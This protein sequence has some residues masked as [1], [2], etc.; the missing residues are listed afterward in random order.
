M[1]TLRPGVSP[2]F[3]PCIFISGPPPPLFLLPETPHA[4][5]PPL[6]LLPELELDAVRGG[7]VV[8]CCRDSAFCS[9]LLRCRFSRRSSSSCNNQTP[10][11]SLD[12]GDAGLGAVEA[13]LW[14]FSMS[15]L[16]PI[17]HL[18]SER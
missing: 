1:M 18:Q 3:A 15:A 16:F 6:P 17:A 4:P 8:C 12:V 9:R 14:G 13:L 11:V 5:L 10:L 7:C 2:T